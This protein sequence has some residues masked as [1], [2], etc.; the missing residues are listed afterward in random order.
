[1]RP[2]RAAAADPDL[3]SPAAAPARL[4]RRRQEAP[5]GRRGHPGESRAVPAGARQP[6]DALGAGSGVRPCPRAPGAPARARLAAR[7]A[8]GAGWPRL[9][10][11]LAHARPRLTFSHARSRTLRLP[12][13]PTDQRRHTTAGSSLRERRRAGRRARNTA[14]AVVKTS[15]SLML[16]PPHLRAA[17]E[18]ATTPSDAGTQKGLAQPRCGAADRLTTW[19]NP[20]NRAARNYKTQNAR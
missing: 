12:S 13:A 19:T 8:A 15:R 18:V 14:V 3:H 7:A 20:V 4:T 6:R 11:L 9:A 5:R 2:G 1:M 16:T 17:L 10:L